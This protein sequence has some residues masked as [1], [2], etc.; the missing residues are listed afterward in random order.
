MMPALL[1][2]FHRPGMTEMVIFAILAFTALVDLPRLVRPFNI[3][4]VGVGTFAAVGLAWAL[5]LARPLLWSHHLKTVFFLICFV[6]YAASTL[7]WSDTGIDGV[8]E[9]VVLAVFLGLILVCARETS[10]DQGRAHTMLQAFLVSSV[11]AILMY[12]Y[13]VYAEISSGA[14]LGDGD[15]AIDPR[16]FAL[17]AMLVVAVSLARWRVARGNRLQQSLPLCWAILTTLLVGCSMSRTALVCC[18]L[19]FPLSMLLQLTAKGVFQAFGMLIAGGVPFALAVEFYP[20]LH[21]RFFGYD[22]SMKLAGV[23]F[24][25]TGRTR[26]WNVVL[27][28]VGDDWVFGKGLASAAILVRSTFNGWIAQPHNDYFRFYHD[29]GLLGLCL[30]LLFAAGFFIRTFDNLRRSVRNQSADYPLHVAAL[31]AFFAVSCSMLTDNSVIYSFVMMPLAVIMGCSLGAGE[32]SVIAVPELE[33]LQSPQPQPLG[34]N[35]RMV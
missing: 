9:L 5:F 8:Q 33:T 27:S 32:P 31:L 17:Y 3:S 4:G 15:D 30:W 25:A 34:R 11:L 14:K 1:K 29:V 35:V 28:N 13:V 12:I 20:P 24:N 7:L 6:A 21:D 18:L 2:K 22:T 26:I 10:F 19:L 23:A 16:S